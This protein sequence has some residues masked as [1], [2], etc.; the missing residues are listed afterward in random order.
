MNPV[1]EIWL[2][3][4]RELR[5]N[6]CS[7]KGLVLLLICMLGAVATSL[8][9]SR[10]SD[11][12]KEKGVDSQQAAGASFE[13]LKEL[14]D[15]TVAKR[16]VGVPA[17]PLAMLIGIVFLLPSFTA[18]VSFDSVSSEL[19]FK[20][21]R[22]WTVR[23]RRVSFFLGKVF[24]VFTLVAVAT[25]VMNM[26]TWIIAIARDVSPFGAT[27]GWGLE[28]WASVL[29][30][31]F[32]WCSMAVF[33]SSL[34]KTPILALLFNFAANLA[35][36]LIYVVAKASQSEVLTYVYPNRYDV[37]LLSSA[38]DRVLMGLAGCFAFAG[39]FLVAGSLLFQR[40]D[41]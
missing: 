13:V 28:L 37:Y 34:V 16:M 5:K 32:A 31:V 30:I 26:L 15:A 8:V 40:R 3:V 19:Q 18:L 38:S 2:L 9:I 21:V 23:V 14:Y 36:G 35:L 1:N 39:V 10:A 29:P 25:L 41:L 22:Y 12:S 20:A 24:G 4:L 27:V 6:L 33:I 11:L 7:V 17:V